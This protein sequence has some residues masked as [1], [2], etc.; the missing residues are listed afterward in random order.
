[1]QRSQKRKRIREP[2]TQTPDY[3]DQK[4]RVS[5]ASVIDKIYFIDENGMKLS[6]TKHH[7]ES[8][9]KPTRFKGQLPPMGLHIGHSLYTTILDDSGNTTE[10]LR[11]EI[12]SIDHELVISK[13]TQPR[14][15]ITLK[16]I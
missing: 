2:L 14:T 16:L 1:M 6:P 3:K 4:K 15:F 7:V 5:T 11:H 12:I 9:G 13:R 10:V 8:G